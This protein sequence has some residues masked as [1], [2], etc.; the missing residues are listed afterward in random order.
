MEVSASAPAES[1][2]APAEGTPNE[3]QP[4]ENQESSPEGSPPPDQPKKHRVKVDGQELE[5]PEE[6]LLKD[7]ELRRAS[8]MRMQQATERS[9]QADQVEKHYKE[10]LTQFKSDPWKLF[11]ALQIDPDLEA[12]QRLL[13]KLEREMMSPEQKALYEKEQHLSARER[14]IKEFEELKKQ[15]EESLAKQEQEELTYKAVQEI[16]TEIG[17]VLK[18]TGKAPTPRTVA[19]VA[20]IMLAHLD[21][22]D[23]ERLGADKALGIFENEMKGE[24]ESYL[25]SLTPE[26]LVQALPKSV[27]DAIRKTELEKVRGTNP[28]KHSGHSGNPSTA[29]AKVKRMSTDSFFDNL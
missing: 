1:A 16:D 19:R 10:L 7:Y 18:A 5:V 21:N 17:E 29:P 23:G 28:L 14:E 6:E 24:I 11:E 4:S 3:S 9:K 20:E 22:E 8:Y 26:Q 12:E 13:K 27:L 25:S 15:H 2:S